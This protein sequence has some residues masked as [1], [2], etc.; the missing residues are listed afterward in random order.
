MEE[1]EGVENTETLLLERLKLGS[2]QTS[3]KVHEAVTG[4]QDHGKPKKIGRLC[5]SYSRITS[6][7]D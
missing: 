7:I 5:I 1:T 2:V 4:S 3:Y 6:H